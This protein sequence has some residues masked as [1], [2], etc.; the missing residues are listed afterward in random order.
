MDFDKISFRPTSQER[1]YFERLNE[2]YNAGSITEF[3]RRFIADCVQW[4]VGG[5]GSTKPTSGEQRMES[6]NIV[7]YAAQPNLYRDPNIGEQQRLWAAQQ[8]MLMQMQMRQQQEAYMQYLFQQQ[9][10]RQLLIQQQ[11]QQFMVPPM[12]M[13]WFGPPFGF[14][15]VAAPAFPQQPASE[16]D[17]S[18]PLSFF[19]K[20]AEQAMRVRDV[21]QALRS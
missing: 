2:H 21:F 6:A 8:Q 19:T 12:G 13:N 7:T 14:P 11:Q 16:S 3:F 10:L 5:I 15:P 1:Q 18:D 20:T 17:S 9:A 4:G